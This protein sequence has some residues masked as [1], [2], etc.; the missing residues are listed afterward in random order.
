MMVRKVMI[1]LALVVLGGLV[2]PL[3]PVTAA[4]ELPD[5]GVVI[6]NEDY[7]LGED[8]SLNG[9]LVIFN[10][11]A[12]LEAG[13]HV[14]GNVVVWNGSAD[15]AG[16]VDGDLIASNGDI[17]LAG[18]AYVVGDVVCT[19]NC[20]IDRGER[21]R[22]DGDVVKGP[23]IR[24]IPFGQFAGPGLNIEI[25]PSDPDPFWLSGAEQLLRWV[26][27]VIRR[28]VTVLVVATIGGLVALIWPEATDRVGQTV[29][30]S[31]GA[32]LGVGL[33]TV[34]AGAALITALTITICLSPAAI[35][36]ALALSAAGLL[37]WIAVGARVG[38]RLLQALKHREVTPLWSASL[39]TLI[40]TLV[41]AGL[42]NAFCLSPLGWLLTFL[43]GAFG[44][45]A[46]ILTRFGTVRYVPDRSAVMAGTPVQPATVE[47]ESSVG[48]SA[49][50]HGVA[51]E[52]EQAS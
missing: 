38:R 12:F 17:L 18:D 7:T 40:V 8:E 32:S 19:W 2:L 50:S 14:R 3:A 20:D 36:L 28:V 49:E 24:G 4:G 37:G 5:D 30:E 26:F 42:S 9:D 16:E 43:V 13:S 22:V 15:V 29:F 47:D 46:V 41:A 45:G 11:D 1:W 25:P 48:T 34:I 27:R 31:P 6:W 39:G 33:L 10:G 35:L 21:T 52:E 23:F 44:L 51:G